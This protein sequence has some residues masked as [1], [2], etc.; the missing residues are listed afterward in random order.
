MEANKETLSEL[1]NTSQSWNHL[2]HML[3][4]YLLNPYI[5]LL[6]GKNANYPSLVGH[7]L[8]KEVNEKVKRNEAAAIELQKSMNYEWKQIFPKRLVEF[9]RLRLLDTTSCEVR[10]IYHYLFLDLVG[11]GKTCRSFEQI[12]VDFMEMLRDYLSRNCPCLTSKERSLPLAELIQTVCKY[13][14]GESHPDGPDAKWTKWNSH[15]LFEELP[16]S[17]ELMRLFNEM[18]KQRETHPMCHYFFITSEFLSGL[19]IYVYMVEFLIF[20]G[21][22]NLPIGAQWKPNLIANLQKYQFKEYCYDK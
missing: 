15:I 21:N 13:Y 2:C 8:Y 9:F 22:R 14:T 5:G 4:D 20:I 11:D 6:Y 17:S 1:L 16:Y 18:A 19:F 3:A 10:T 12:T 7:Q